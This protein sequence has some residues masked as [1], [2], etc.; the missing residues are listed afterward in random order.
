ME[1][2]ASLQSSATQGLLVPRV[3][4]RFYSPS[5]YIYVLTFRRG[6]V[7]KRITGL[8]WVGDSH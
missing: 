6:D 5:V 2:R 7:C 4:L 3:L 8:P 1:K